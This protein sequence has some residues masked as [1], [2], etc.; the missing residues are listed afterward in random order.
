MWTEA[1][2]S[3]ASRRRHKLDL[4]RL[5]STGL[6]DGAEIAGTQPGFGEDSDEH[7]RVKLV[8]AG[9]HDRTPG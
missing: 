2:A 5:I 9:R 4:D 7:Y 1:S 8:E 3:R 6:N